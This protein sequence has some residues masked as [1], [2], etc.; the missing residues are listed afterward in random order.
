MH[1]EED[2]VG[3]SATDKG[4][5]TGYSADVLIERTLGNGAVVDLEGGY[6]DWDTDDSLITPSP[7]VTP[8]WSWRAT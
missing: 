7:R 5:F 2:G 3:S 8:S 4:D 6:Y 1:L